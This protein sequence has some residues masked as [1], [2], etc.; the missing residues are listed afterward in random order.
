MLALLRSVKSVYQ[1]TSLSECNPSIFDATVSCL[2]GQSI[3][4]QYLF[5]SEIFLTN[6]SSFEAFFR[7]DW[8]FVMAQTRFAAMGETQKKNSNQRNPNAK[9]QQQHQQHQRPN[10][11]KPVSVSRPCNVG[12]ANLG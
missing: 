6:H 4:T 12:Q 5:R 1:R 8:W 2:L 9:Q 3:R 7:F 10:K 11:K